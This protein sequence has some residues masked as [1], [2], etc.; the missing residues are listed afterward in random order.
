MLPS[1]PGDGLTP[2]RARTVVLLPLSGGD[3]AGQR[4]RA[5][6]RLHDL[7]LAVCR[8]AARDAGELGIEA[9]ERVGWGGAHQQR[10]VVDGAAVAARLVAG[11]VQRLHDLLTAL[12]GRD[13]DPHTFIGRPD[14][15][16]G[17][18]V[19]VAEGKAGKPLDLPRVGAGLV[20]WHQRS[21]SS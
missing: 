19:A 16:D 20:S 18:A 3:S 21:R 2:L 15:L 12:P 14:L 17:V 9:E 11:A 6:P 13:L 4:L 1:A 8:K 7:T 10:L 5:L